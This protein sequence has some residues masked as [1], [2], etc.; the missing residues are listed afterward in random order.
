MSAPNSPHV[1]PRKGG[2]YMI[3]K[4]LLLDDNEH[5]FEIPVSAGMQD[6]S[7]FTYL[8]FLILCFILLFTFNVIF[9][10]YTLN[11]VNF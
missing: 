1:S 10:I 2:K 6:L 7:I 9:K 3:A 11:V 4:V 5:M 8:C